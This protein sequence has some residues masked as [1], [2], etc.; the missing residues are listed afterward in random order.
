M[1]DQAGQ[2]GVTARLA[3]RLGM[4]PLEFVDIFGAGWRPVDG[5]AREG[6]DADGGS[7]WFIA[8]DPV[9]LML[10]VYPHG[11]FL[12]RPE[13]VWDHGAQALAYRQRDQVF[14]DVAGICDL[15]RLRELIDRMV[16]VR[17]TTFGYCRC[18]RRIVGPEMLSDARTCQDC[19]QTWS[20]PAGK[21]QAQESL[22]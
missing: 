5:V 9:Q 22:S 18:C 11:V 16:R 17:R 21:P 6:A 20:Q 7:A 8:G 19:S 12:A 14:V 1:V 2:H 15:E 4:A 10:R 13:G 3:A